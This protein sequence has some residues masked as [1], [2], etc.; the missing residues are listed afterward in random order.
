[1]PKNTGLM[2]NILGVSGPELPPRGTEP[3][4]F[5]GVQSSLGGHGPEMPPRGAGPVPTTLMSY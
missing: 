2:T 1:M 5:F 4:T 3:V